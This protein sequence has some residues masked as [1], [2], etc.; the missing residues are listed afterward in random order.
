MGDVGGNTWS[1]FISGIP[2]AQGGDTLSVLAMGLQRDGI[3][4]QYVLE[5]QL[6][7]FVTYID[8]IGQTAIRGI[9]GLGH[10]TAIITL[11]N[12]IDHSLGQCDVTTTET[13]NGLLIVAYPIAL[14]HEV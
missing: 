1:L 6:K 3:F 14:L 11:C 8:D 7:S 4:S 10:L 2:I 5:G 12:S 9:E 13:I